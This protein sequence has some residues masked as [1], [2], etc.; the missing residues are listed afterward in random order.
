MI[1]EFHRPPTAAGQGLGGF[2]EGW[3]LVAKSRVK[4][5]AIPGVVLILSFDFSS[6]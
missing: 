6:V 5:L 4:S 1:S 2:N 3:S